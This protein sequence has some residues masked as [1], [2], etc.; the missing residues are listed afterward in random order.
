MYNGLSEVNC[1]FNE[2]K[3]LVFFVS[4]GFSLKLERPVKLSLSFMKLQ[5]AQQLLEAVY[6]QKTT[7]RSRSMS[8]GE[9]SRSSEPSGLQG[10]I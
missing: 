6:P 9:S 2:K 8:K 4:A 7:T 10:I 5:Q 1:I 3:I